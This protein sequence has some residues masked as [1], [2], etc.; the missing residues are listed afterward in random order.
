MLSKVPEVTAFF[1]IIKVLCTT[2]GETAA[3]LLS[4]NLGL[5]LTLT[6]GVMTMLLVVCLGVQLR[7]RRYIP[8][9][10]WLTVAL[11]SV[12][13]TLVSDNLTDNLGVPLATTTVAFALALAIAFAAWYQ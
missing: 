4:D 10:Y 3:D 5:G 6:S 2:V 9:V 1:W 12:V 8:G 11:V 7:A 13:G